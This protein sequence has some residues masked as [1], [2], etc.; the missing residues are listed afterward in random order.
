LRP[1]RRCAHDPRIPFDLYGHTAYSP[2]VRAHILYCTIDGKTYG[3]ERRYGDHR[4]F[5]RGTGKDQQAAH[6]E[7]K[8]GK[9]RSRAHSGRGGAQPTEQTSSPGGPSTGGPSPCA[10]HAGRGFRGNTR[11]GGNNGWN[12]NPI[13][14]VFT[15]RT[16]G[17]RLGTRY[18]RG[19]A[20]PRQFGVGTSLHGARRAQQRLEIPAADLRVARH[21][22]FKG[23][24]GEKLL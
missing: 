16:T 18:N 5:L 11:T 19:Q 12:P 13:V 20:G 8:H 15:S 14:G 10:G 22:I 7:Q 24:P 1:D 9:E 23:C 4:G 2:S 3:C 17:V 6:G 21:N